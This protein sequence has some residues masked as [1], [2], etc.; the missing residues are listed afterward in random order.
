MKGS[1]SS[2]VVSQPP[3]NDLGSK[4]DTVANADNLMDATSALNTVGYQSGVCVGGILEK[5]GAVG[6]RLVDSGRGSGRVQVVVGAKVA[7]LSVSDMMASAFWKRF[8][9][10]NREESEEEETD[11]PSTFINSRISGGLRIKDDADVL[12][13]ESWLFC[14]VN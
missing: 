11:S 8:G 4:L 3:Q 6:G 12:D 14:V 2:D 1:S 7:S 10:S 5:A 13:A 9:S